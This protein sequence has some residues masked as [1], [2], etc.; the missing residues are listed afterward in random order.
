[1]SQSECQFEIR[2]DGIK[3]SCGGD[4][5][6]FVPNQAPLVRGERA[7][8]IVDEMRAALL[9]MGDATKYRRR[10]AMPKPVHTLIALRS[11]NSGS[12]SYLSHLTGGQ[13]DGRLLPRK[14]AR[15]FELSSET[16]SCHFWNAHFPKRFAF[17]PTGDGVLLHRHRDGEKVFRVVPSYELHM[18][19]RMLPPAF[20]S[21][22][23]A[24]TSISGK[25]MGGDLLRAL[26]VAVYV[27]ERH[28]ASVEVRVQGRGETLLE[29]YLIPVLETVAGAT[30]T[31]WGRATVSLR[32]LVDEWSRQHE[33][34]IRRLVEDVWRR[35]Q[36]ELRVTVRESS[37]KRDA[38]HGTEICLV[39]PR[40]GDEHLLRAYAVLGPDVEKYTIV[41]RPEDTAS[42]ML[43]SRFRCRDRGAAT[44]FEW[45]P[46]TARAA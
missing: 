14:F 29:G 24:D 22:L 6:L 7:E 12:P 13:K 42:T 35:A 33:A 45:S 38:S 19:D 10:F 23:S 18:A 31:S 44:A 11:L 41:T 37:V 4:S 5:V 40:E 16:L 1:M 3:G 21:P 28:S 30:R 9:A 34:R 2:W 20:A 8:F 32:I 26:W 15:D 46:P 43:R 39:G 25:P 36:L 17:E 27:A